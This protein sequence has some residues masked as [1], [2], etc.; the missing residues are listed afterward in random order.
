MAGKQKNVIATGTADRVLLENALRALRETTGIEAKTVTHA[1]RLPNNRQADAR[2]TF[3]APLR[4]YFAEIRGEMTP[5]R[6][7]PVLARLRELPGPGLL[8]T[9]YVT[10][11]LAERLRNE[12]VQFLDAAGN[13]YLHQEKPPCHIYIT[14]R[15]P[16]ARA[17]AERPIKAFRAVGLK[18]V[19]P[20]I[21]RPATLQA[22]YREI[23]ELAGVALGTVAQTMTDLKR[24]GLLRRTRTGHTL[25]DRRKL[26]DMW[27]DAY[28]RELRPRL[29]PR[30]YHVDDPDWWKKK[31][32]IPA[33]MWL[34][35]EAGAALLTKYLRLE[36]VTIYGD[37]AFTELAR[38]IRPIKDERGNLEV[39][40]AFWG[41][42][43]ET[44]VPGYRL[45][46][47]L[48]VYADL[49]V[50]GEARNLETAQMIRERFLDGA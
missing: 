42:E 5:A 26:I 23:A 11:P 1:P 25:Q 19:F 24:L 4:A 43:P 38:Q 28:P 37:K 22:T 8:V 46:P 35:G 41:F 14:G 16:E 31:H 17:A 32:A 45:V 36:V 49:I 6:L 40:E 34:G 3:K 39:L 18:V 20:L 9:R 30:R 10:P 33:D 12:G 2:I 13:A 27:V 48:L 50:S 21:C 47:P 15:K 7:G 44:V 29:K